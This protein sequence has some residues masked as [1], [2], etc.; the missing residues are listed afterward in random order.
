MISGFKIVWTLNAKE[1]LEKTIEY[2]ENNFSDK[3]IKKLV[4]KIED[5]TELISQNPNLFQKSE[6]NQI[7]KVVILKF[8]TLY[9]RSTNESI[10]I[11]SFFSNRQ[12]PK[13][14]EK[15]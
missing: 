5:I 11:L 7:Y 2:L 9:Y 13:K 3:E 6:N 10:E 8:N 4:Q 15:Y 1:E 12:N 14:T